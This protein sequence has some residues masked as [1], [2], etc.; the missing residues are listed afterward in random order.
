MQ[1][2]WKCSALAV[3]GEVTCGVLLGTMHMNVLERPAKKA[4]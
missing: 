4:G 2:K 3:R 1:G